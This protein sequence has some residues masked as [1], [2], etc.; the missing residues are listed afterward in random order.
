MY[1]LFV[2][3][4]YSLFPLNYYVII[5][6]D[7]FQLVACS[8]P[9]LLARIKTHWLW[10]DFLATLGGYVCPPLGYWSNAISIE[11]ATARV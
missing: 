4:F 3:V 7:G 11:P 8:E 9:Q 5:S 6:V 10:I 2:V 1:T